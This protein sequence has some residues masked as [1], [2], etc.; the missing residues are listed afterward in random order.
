MQDNVIYISAS[1]EADEQ[2]AYV[3]NGQPVFRISI[4]KT[5][6][7]AF[8]IEMAIGIGAIKWLF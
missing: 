7:V 4:W 5:I 1:P 6:A 3:E 2:I 8:L